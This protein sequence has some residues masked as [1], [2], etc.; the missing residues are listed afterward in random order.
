MAKVKL[1][2]EQVPL[3]LVKEKIAQHEEAVSKQNESSPNNRKA[4]YEPKTAT[5]N[6]R[7]R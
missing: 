5:K 4:G 2:I 3:D 1:H 6:L 7:V